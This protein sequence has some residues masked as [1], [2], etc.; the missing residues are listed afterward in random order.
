MSCVFSDVAFRHAL[1]VGGA[2]I[3]LNIDIFASSARRL[4]Y[5]LSNSMN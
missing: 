2:V 5:T 4:M 3:S 1:V